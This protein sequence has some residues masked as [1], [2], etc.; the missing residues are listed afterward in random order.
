MMVLVHVSSKFGNLKKSEKLGM[1]N[2][3]VISV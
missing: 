3:L 1:R 2:K